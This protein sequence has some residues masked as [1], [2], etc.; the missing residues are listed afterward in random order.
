MEG[1]RVV[2]EVRVKFEGGDSRLRRWGFE[3]KMVEIVKID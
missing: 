2:K 3:V 1:W